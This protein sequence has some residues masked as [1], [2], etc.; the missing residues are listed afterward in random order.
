MEFERIGYVNSFVCKH[1]GWMTV[2]MNLN[3]GVTCSV[4]GCQ[5]KDLETGR[6]VTD[7]IIEGADPIAP[8]GSNNP[9][10]ALNMEYIPQLAWF[11][12][13]PIK[14]VNLESAEVEEYTL[15]RMVIDKLWIR[16]T[17]GHIKRVFPRDN[18]QEIID[19]CRD[20]GLVLTDMASNWERCEPYADYGKDEKV[21][22]EY[23]VE[24]FPLDITV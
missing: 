23:L 13:M 3:N 5:G 11:V 6:K 9:H 15:P 10:L 20:G 14:R 24:M 18:Q 8:G 12:D 1:C 2:T 17:I 4:I 22:R 19:M 21:T 16:P 7:G